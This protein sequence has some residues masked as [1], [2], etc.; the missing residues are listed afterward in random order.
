MLQKLNQTFSLNIAFV[1][2]HYSF[3]SP[4][5]L[6]Y[7]VLVFHCKQTAKTKC[8]IASIYYNIVIH[9]TLV[10]IWIFRLF[11][12]LGYYKQCFYKHSWAYILG[13]KILLY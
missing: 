5:I 13:P 11:P 1:T 2:Q 12:E 8:Y 7:I 6:S 3:K 10:D 4:F 9:S